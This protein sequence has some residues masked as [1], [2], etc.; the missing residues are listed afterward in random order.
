MRNLAPF[1]DRQIRLLEAVREKVFQI[2]D[3]DPDIITGDAYEFHIVSTKQFG[4]LPKIKFHPGSCRIKAELAEKSGIIDKIKEMEIVC[5]RRSYGVSEARNSRARL[6]EEEWNNIMLK[7]K[8]AAFTV[9]L[10]NQLFTTM[11]QTASEPI[12][13]LQQIIMDEYAPQIK[14]KKDPIGTSKCPKASN[15]IENEGI[16]P[17]DQE[18][19]EHE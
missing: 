12:Q 11:D 7:A 3:P 18:L 9:A 2:E 17:Y 19:S 13:L 14:A 6:F 5:L 4:R 1:T 16:K 10:I 8:K 15:S